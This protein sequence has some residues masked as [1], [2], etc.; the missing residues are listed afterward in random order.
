M[1]KYPESSLIKFFKF[2]FS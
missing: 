1:L 2:P